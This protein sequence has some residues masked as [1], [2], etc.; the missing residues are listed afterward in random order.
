MTRIEKIQE[1]LN[2][3][4]HDSFLNHALAMENIKEGEH[5]EA[6]SILSALLLRDP[7]YVGSYYHLAKLYE[8]TNQPALAEATY[9]SGLQMAQKANDKHSFNELRSALD[10]LIS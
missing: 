4:P 3:D 10:E 9:E 7:G 6:I 1:M 2:G 8:L 5:Q